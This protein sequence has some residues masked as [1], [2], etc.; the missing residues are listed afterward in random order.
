MRPLLIAA[1]WFFCGASLAVY[2]WLWEMWLRW[3][4]EGVRESDN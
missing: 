4:W 2:V 1:I 3:T